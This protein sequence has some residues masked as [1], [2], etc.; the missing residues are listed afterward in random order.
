[1]KN[2]FSHL[3]KNFIT[4]KLFHLNKINLESH[5]WSNIDRHSFLYKNSKK[6]INQEETNLINYYKLANEKM[7]DINNIKFFE[8]FTIKNKFNCNNKIY[9]INKICKNNVENLY[10]KTT[11]S[12]GLSTLCSKRF[13]TNVSL[14][15]IEQKK[16]ADSNKKTSKNIKE[17]ENG[18]IEK[19]DIGKYINL[20][21]LNNDKNIE[22]DSGLGKI[23]NTTNLKNKKNTN[24]DNSNV[25]KINNLC[26]LKDNNSE[27][28]NMSNNINKNINDSLD[29]KNFEEKTKSIK[30]KSLDN[31]SISTTNFAFKKTRKIFY[32]KQL[33]F[34]SK[35]KTIRND[36]ISNDLSDDFI[37]EDHGTELHPNDPFNK[38]LTSEI[39]N[40]ENSEDEFNENNYNRNP[41]ENRKTILNKS[42]EKAKLQNAIKAKN[43]INSDKNLSSL[44][45]SYDTN[46]F[47]RNLNLNK[48]KKSYE[49]RNED[50]SEYDKVIDILYYLSIQFNLDKFH[51]IIE[52]LQETYNNDNNIILQKLE[53]V[54]IQN[55]RIIDTNSKSNLIL[56][57]SKALQKKKIKFNENTWNEIYR[58]FQVSLELNILTFRDFYNYTLAF[59]KIKNIILASR[60]KFVNDFENFIGNDN[61]NL[62]NSSKIKFNNLDDIILFSSLIHSKIFKIGSI[63]D[64]VWLSL[65]ELIKINSLSLNVNTLLII[66]SLLI[67][68]SEVSQKANILLI[69]SVNEINKFIN[70]VFLNFEFLDEQEKANLIN[71]S[72]SLFNFYL[73]FIHRNTQ[74]NSANQYKPKEES[75][76]DKYHFIFGNDGFLIKNLIKI[77]S[78]KIKLQNN[79]NF[80][81]ELRI[82]IFLTKELKYYEK[83]FWSYCAENLI[84]FIKFDFMTKISDIVPKRLG[85]SSTPRQRATA[86]EIEEMSK[87]FYYGVIIEVFSSV[88]YY[89]PEFWD[90]ILQKFDEIIPNSK[91]EPLI[92][93]QF[94]SL[95]CKKLY[96]NRNFDKIYES[97]VNKF[98]PEFKR[99]FINREI[100]DFLIGVNFLH[101]EFDREKNYKLILDL[102]NPMYIFRPLNIY[103]EMETPIIINNINN[104][105]KSIINNDIAN[106]INKISDNTD[107]NNNTDISKKKLFLDVNKNNESDSN[108]NDAH[109]KLHKMISKDNFKDINEIEESRIK[110]NDSINDKIDEN[111]LNAKE[112]STASNI[113]NK[114]KHINKKEDEKESNNI[115]LLITY[116]NLI[117]SK[118]IFEEEV[119]FFN[120][121]FLIKLL[122]LIP[123][124]FFLYSKIYFGFFQI[125]FKN[126]FIY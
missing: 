89:E 10:L 69:D 110:I 95:H 77:Y 116:L 86:L 73:I 82:L 121:Q 47:N 124:S 24:L 100:L 118:S 71:F 115:L 28:I 22:E 38:I 93:L 58:D 37:I 12:R 42:L 112:D 109:D 20:K 17:D 30:I 126:I 66:S 25:L 14:E 13:S 79:F 8:K 85:N 46:N 103:A 101:K 29:K 7:V 72:D 40:K 122:N 26:V 113:I 59:E 80:F 99:I 36:L 97:L 3:K 119:N 81:L 123:Y 125:I 70:A 57:I 4:N 48:L 45:I 63:S 78:E 120:N 83:D 88:N 19:E 27:M 50:F 23:E 52:Y 5:Y 55:I 75:N 35:N 87:L 60:P 54:F 16:K 76:R 92:L 108:K 39:E 31:S 106:I 94:I 67:N 114:E 91:K 51:Y 90:L 96:R 56:I 111:Q 9:K 74:N 68:L 102:I 2:F 61:I 33:K 34:Q 43:N 64:S 32:N 107:Q 105:N 53:D 21:N 117:W 98:S 18:K 1:M 15:E 62:L 44:D 84:N 65:N 104:D 11:N 49:F 41:G 6:I